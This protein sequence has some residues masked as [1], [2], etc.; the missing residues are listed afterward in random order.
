MNFFILLKSLLFPKT[1]SPQ[2]SPVFC[3][4]LSIQL[5]FS[6]KIFDT[7]K[8]LIMSLMIFEATFFS[9]GHYLGS[10]FLP[11]NSQKSS[12]FSWGLCPQTPVNFSRY[13]LYLGENIF[14]SNT[15]AK[16]TLPPLPKKRKRPDVPPHD[17]KKARHWA[18]NKV[19]VFDFAAGIMLDLSYFLEFLRNVSLMKYQKFPEGFA[20]DPQFFL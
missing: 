1:R 16:P 18:H 4:L 19:K 14:F 17:A 12:K 13:F 11:G 15:A 2:D 9:P 3:R 8:N 6:G 5:S 20:P 10:I 7:S